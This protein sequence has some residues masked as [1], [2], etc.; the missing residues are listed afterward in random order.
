MPR[1]A[2]P[3]CAG[4]PAAWPGRIA[5]SAASAGRA[6]AG[7]GDLPPR[8]LLEHGADHGQAP[9][10]VGVQQHLEAL[11]SADARKGH[12]RRAVARRHAHEL[13]PLRPEQAVLLALALVR[14]AR[15][16]RHICVSK[17]SAS[18][19]CARWGSKVREPLR[20]TAQS[21]PPLAINTQIPACQGLKFCILHRC[22]GHTWDTT[23]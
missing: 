10:L 21:S 15:R 4:T 18:L 22:I 5:A 19:I 16:G 13:G 1:T 6:P 7:L 14:L 8:A 11:L 2:P 9:D 23:A 17:A 3:V 20:R 12:D